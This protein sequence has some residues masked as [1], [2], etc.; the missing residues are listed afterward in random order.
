MLDLIGEGL[1]LRQKL[2]NL[3]V[4][5]SQA[6]SNESAD[7]PSWLLKI[8]AAFAESAT[9]TNKNII[10]GDENKPTEEVFAEIADLAAY[11]TSEAN[12]I[13]DSLRKNCELNIA[14][15][16]MF[17]E[18]VHTSCKLIICNACEYF[19]ADPVG[20]GAGIGHCAFGIEWTEEFNGRKP[21]FRYAERHCDKFRKLSGKF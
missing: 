4:S 5:N 14:H 7:T 20:D 6:I 15:V 21:L 19:T 3:S 11:Q 1:A 16:L 13:A 10:G 2:K 12:D 9:L 18:I 8:S 17:N